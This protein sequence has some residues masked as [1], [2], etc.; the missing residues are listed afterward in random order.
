MPHE[1]TE[2]HWG[3]EYLGIMTVAIPEGSAPNGEFVMGLGLGA[4]LDYAEGLLTSSNEDPTVEMGRTL[5]DPPLISFATMTIHD[6][7]TINASYQSFTSSINSDYWDRL[8]DNT[9]SGGPPRGGYFNWIFN[10]KKLKA[11]NSDSINFKVYA[12][13]RTRDYVSH[14]RLAAAIVTLRF[15][16][17]DDYKYMKIN[18]TSGLISF[19]PRLDKTLVSPV[20]KLTLLSSVSKETVMGTED[21]DKAL[22]DVARNAAANHLTLCYVKRKY[23]P[24]ALQDDGGGQKNENPTE[25]SSKHFCI[26][27]VRAVDSRLV[28]CR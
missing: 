28:I 25:L 3:G 7:A 4:R 19:N 13:F 15:Y 17:T 26:V 23:G 2:V 10:T 20:K 9:G 12:V 18:E 14:P 27:T 1:I 22:V 24:H 11:L 21:A 5:T 16:E 6:T 8:E